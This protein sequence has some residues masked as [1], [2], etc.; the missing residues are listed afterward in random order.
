ML[1]C[2]YCRTSITP[3]QCNTSAIRFYF[4]VFLLINVLASASSYGQE[5]RQTFFGTGY[6]EDHAHIYLSPR[7]VLQSNP[8]EIIPPHCIVVSN[9]SPRRIGEHNIRFVTVPA[10]QSYGSPL[11]GF[12]KEADLKTMYLK[13]Q[14]DFDKGKSPRR[15]LESEI[16]QAIKDNQNIDK[17]D[18]DIEED[19]SHQLPEPYFARAEAFLKQGDY[20]HAMLDYFDGLRRVQN[21]ESKGYQY[22][23]YEKYFDKLKES[24]EGTLYQPVSTVALGRDEID[25]AGRHFSSG[26]TAFWNCQY[27]G[28]LKEFNNSIEIVWSCPIFWYYR[29]LTYWKL[30]D[31]EKAAFNLIMG[32]VMEKNSLE[33]QLEKAEKNA[34]EREGAGKVLRDDKY[35]LQVEISEYLRRF[36]GNDRVFLEQIRWGDPSNLI[37]KEFFAK[38]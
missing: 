25:T 21:K 8:Y 29:G 13:V 36:Q 37:M 26:Y 27:D 6:P 3:V 4:H 10:I 7:D 18:Q 12:M 23:L 35:Q 20:G 19:K 2:S 22:V 14:T 38:P 31:K 16:E 28:A 17:D 5:R 11:V 30:G 1:R 9:A 32:S 34:R 33:R 24:I 15:V